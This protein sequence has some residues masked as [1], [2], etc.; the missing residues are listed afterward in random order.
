MDLQGTF[1]YFG[2]NLNRWTAG[3]P[4]KSYLNAKRA[5][6]GKCKSRLKIA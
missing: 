3:I 6:I 5:V 2:S 4:D 1:K